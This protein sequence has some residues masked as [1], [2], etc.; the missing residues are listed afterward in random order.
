MIFSAATYS[1]KAFLVGQHTHP[2]LTGETYIRQIG[3]QAF[4]NASARYS[5]GTG[6]SFAGPDLKAGL[7]SVELSAIIYTGVKTTVLDTVFYWHQGQ[8]SPPADETNSYGYLK[9]FDGTQGVDWTC[10]TALIFVVEKPY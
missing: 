5:G 3:Y 1:A 10:T 8:A 7:G 2:T 4:S 9:F 6:T